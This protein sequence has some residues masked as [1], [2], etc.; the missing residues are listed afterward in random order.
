MSMVPPTA[1]VTD[2]GF[3]YDQDLEPGTQMPERTLR[4]IV[5][6]EIRTAVGFVGGDVSEQRRRAMNYY[7][8]D[9][10][11]NE[12]EDRSTVVSTDVQDTIESVMPE[13]M[14]IF[15]GGDKIVTF[16]PG[17]PEDTDMAAQA[18]DYANFIWN[19]DNPGFEITH[20][21]IKD[22]L[23]QKNGMIKIYWEDHVESK[24]ETIE[25]INSLVLQEL[26]D[27]P[28]VEVVEHEEYPIEDEELLPFAPDGI[29]HDLSIIRHRKNGKVQV[30][31]VPPEEFLIARRSVS[32]IDAA[33]TCH[34]VRKTASDLIRMGYS[35]ETVNDIPSHDDQDYNEERVSRFDDDEWPELDDSLD[36][37]M[38]EIWLY[39]CYLK[40]D[41]DGDGVAE[42]RQVTVAGPGYKVLENEAIDDHPF[43]FVTP[44]KMPHKFFGRSLADLTMDIQL[45]KSTIQRQLLDN[46]YLINNARDAI[47]NRVDLDDYLVKRPGAPIRVHTDNPDV[48]GHIT[49]VPTQS[50]GAYAYPLLEYMDSI[51]EMRTGITRLGQGLD[52]NA[53]DTTARGMN[54]LLGRTQRRI[55]LMARTMAEVGFK[56]AFRK[57]LKLI[58][59][60][61]DR[62]RVIRLRNQWVPMDPR[63]WNAEMD[64]EVSVGLGYGTKESQMMMLERILEKQLGIVNLQGGVNGPLVTLDEAFATLR[65]WV[66]SMGIKDAESHFKDPQGQMIQQPEPPPDPKL[67]EVQQKGQLEARKLQL[68]L[69]KFRAE[70]AQNQEE[71]KQKWAQ[72]E[73][74]YNVDVEKAGIERDRTAIEIAKVSNE[75]DIQAGDQELKAREGQNGQANDI[76]KGLSE[77][78]KVLAKAADGAGEDKDKAFKEASEQLNKVAEMMSA[79]KRVVRDDKGNITGVET[80]K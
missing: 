19:S 1:K 6:E 68:E 36:P 65:K 7:H 46:M 79:P 62:S 75:A 30:V 80:V 64:A 13:M 72:L 32:L 66:H 71:L 44:I 33:F 70:T 29:L 22:G 53:L 56:P 3:L 59:N 40:V 51:R 45:I 31:S 60:R 35:P 38:R 17:G 15:A 63:S 77:A 27:D 50:L 54:M 4:S 11:G 18:T 28:E 78:A 26:L 42:M 9:P 16:K 24:R 76:T 21:W 57:I 74:Q 41:F 12:Q 5:E 69:E 39:E 67:I 25:R 49:P 20:D 61:Q 23:L 52:P 73:L 8:G 14:E 55:L 58:V 2:S 37:S 10:F 43:A 34:K 48:Q 47:S